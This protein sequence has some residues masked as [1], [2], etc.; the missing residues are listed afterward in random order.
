MVSFLGTVRRSVAVLLGAGLLFLATPSFA[1]PD[2]PNPNANPN[3]PGQIKKGMSVPELG[4]GAA[5]AGLVVAAGVL[6]VMSSRRRKR[7]A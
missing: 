2:G 6:L 5:G 4:L 7:S 3:A 1:K